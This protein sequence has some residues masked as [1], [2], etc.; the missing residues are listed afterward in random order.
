MLQKTGK[1]SAKTPAGAA[2]VWVKPKRCEK[3]AECWFH[4]TRRWIWPGRKKTDGYQI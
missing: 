4:Q 2:E 1:E 3:P